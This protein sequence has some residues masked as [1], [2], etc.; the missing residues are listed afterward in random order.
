MYQLLADTVLV[1]HFLFIVFVLTGGLLAFRWPRIA[2]LHIPATAWGALIEFMGWIC[3]LT[4]LENHFLRLGNETTYQ[5]D[6]ISRYIL[7]II[8]P[9]GL[10]PAIQ[11]MLGSIVIFLNGIIYTLVIL[12]IRR[13]GIQWT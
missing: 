5:G 7:P 10:T 12:R 9:A 3:P 11:V 6:F 4:P 1:V 13:R 8:Y 2:W